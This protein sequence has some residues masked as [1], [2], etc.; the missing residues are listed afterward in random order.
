M[1]TLTLTGAYLQRNR[2]RQA[3]IVLL[4]ILLHVLGVLIFLNFGHKVQVPDQLIRVSIVTRKAPPAA[5]H[6]LSRN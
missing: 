5:S 2:R 4:V 1:P 6:A 3:V